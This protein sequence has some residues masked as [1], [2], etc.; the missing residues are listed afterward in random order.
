M[1]R[2]YQILVYTIL[3]LSLSYNYFTVTALIDCQ[4][5][6]LK[7]ENKANKIRLVEDF[8]AEAVPNSPLPAEYA[9]Y[10][11]KHG[12]EFNID[13][14]L[15]AVVGRVES[16][17]NASAVSDEGAIGVQQIMPF[18]V[19][20]IPFLKSTEDL[21]DPDINI[22]ASAYILAHYRELCGDSVES[23]AG[24]YHGGP[25]A[26]TDPKPSTKQFKLAVSNLF[27][28]ST[29]TVYAGI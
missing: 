29:S 13:P 12:K 3:A 23:M 1:K 28:E 18:W 17:Y 27:Y 6:Q 26:R 8:I 14:M 16:T 2:L 15:L 25:R 9:R 4:D 7:L 20:A 22:R 24:C 5:T 21:Y 10:Y 11:I 19:K